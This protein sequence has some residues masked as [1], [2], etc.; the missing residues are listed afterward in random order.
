[1]NKTRYLIPL[2]LACVIASQLGSVFADDVV[3][4]LGVTTSSSPLS[5]GKKGSVYFDV[6]NSGTYDV[7]EADAILASTSTSISVLNP[8]VVFNTILS[9][10]HAYFNATLM[11]DQGAGVG[12]YQLTFSLSY[13][14]LGR[15]VTVAVPVTLFV[16]HSFQPMLEVSTPSTGIRIAGSNNITI[17]LRNMANETLTDIDLLTSTS[18]TYVYLNSTRYHVASLS[19]GGLTDLRCTLTS[20]ENTPVGVYPLGVTIFYSDSADDRL[21]QTS[22][23]SYEVASPNIAESPILTVTD[24]TSNTVVPGQEFNIG[25][26][27]TCSGAEV[28][29]AKATLAFDSKGLLS[30]MSP[31]SSSLGD[32][33]PGDVRKLSFNL[34]IDG[35]APAGTLPLTLTMKYV[36]SKSIQGTA[37]EVIS[38]PVDEIANFGFLEDM[39]AVAEVGN[40]STLE[41]DLLL[42]GTSRL[43]FVRI[44]AVPD[45]HIT[46]VEGSRQYVGAVDTD[47]P[48]P[49][50]LKYAVSNGTTPGTYS[51]NLKVTWV[52]HRNLPREQTLTLPLTVTKPTP[53]AT[54][55]V[56]TGFWGWLRRILGI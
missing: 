24:V 4:H 45:G 51:L 23:L 1:M 40:T 46:Q 53:V 41:A 29:N 49:F 33:K 13:M 55:P 10:K 28:H 5:A 22:T 32:M 18:S 39:T 56:D 7:Y 8:Q 42:T 2:V 31:T 11:V 52:N 43:E 15:A 19:P 20:L 21:K 27:I 17:R 38:V 9:K 37:T 30:P 50:S 44:E 35:S 12:S 48:V 34:L 26:S 47:S 3:P 6:Y 36:D 25:V 14:R 54:K 16:N